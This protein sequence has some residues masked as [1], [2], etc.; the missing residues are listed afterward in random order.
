MGKNQIP[1]NS[2]IRKSLTPYLC[3]VK[4]NRQR[5]AQE[6]PGMSSKDMMTSMGKMW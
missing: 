2:S 6:N 4:E 5:V 1:L 3:F